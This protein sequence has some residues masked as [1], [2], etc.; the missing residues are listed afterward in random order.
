VTPRLLRGQ[1]AGP[2]LVA[3]L[4]LALLLAVLPAMASAATTAKVRIDF[5]TST[6]FGPATVTLP[7]APVAPADAADA[8]DGQACAADSA[9]GAIHAA[10]GGDWS[11][12]WSATTGWSLY[13]VK[14][15]TANGSRWV[16][17][18][19]G[20]VAPAP[21]TKILEE[22][23]YV[24]AYPVCTTATTNCF[25]RGHLDLYSPATIGERAPLAVQVFQTV[26]TFDDQ[27]NTLTLTGPSTRTRVDGPDGWTLTDDYFGNATLSLS[28][29]GDNT[30]YTA[31]N[32]FVPDAAAVC[33]SNGAD[34]Y[35]G[36]TAPPPNAFDPLN[37]CQTTGFDGYCG[38]PD[39][40]PPSAKIVDPVQGK[41]YPSAGGPTVITGTATFDPSGIKQINLR[42]MRQVTVTKSK[43]VRRKVTVKKRVHGKLVK[44]RVTKRVK[45][46][47]KAK[48]CYGF[49]L[50]TSSWGALKRC[51]ATLA[52]TFT[53]GGGDSWTTELPIALP[54]GAY[55]LDAQAQDGAG[56]IDAAPEI[57]RNRVTFTVK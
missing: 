18:V 17:F 28:N 21:C 27:G 6:L 2:V 23:A 53:T 49:K 4:T 15:L 11:G 20:A 35:C 51:D 47:Y 3:L 44:K 39:Q 38:T 37:F 32:G 22:N 34:G 57:G 30:I 52:P 40:V 5:P 24:R 45:K 7:S 19:N 26:V 54:N 8:P 33:V 29:Q 50:K 43:W 46:K 12:T 14:T 13:R 16:V 36:T 25:T 10:I 31:K 41:G 9:L 42:V 1:T 56:N 55:T 48:A